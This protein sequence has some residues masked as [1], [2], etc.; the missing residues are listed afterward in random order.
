MK[1]STSRSS[2]SKVIANV[3]FCCTHTGAIKTIYPLEFPYRG[4]KKGHIAKSLLIHEDNISIYHECEDGVEK[5][6]SR[7]TVW[8][9]EAC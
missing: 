3:K 1:L 8:H 5:S 6:I 2:S 4:H 9:H 7:I